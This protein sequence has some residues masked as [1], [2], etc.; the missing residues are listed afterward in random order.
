MLRSKLRFKRD[1]IVSV[2]MKTA[3]KVAVIV[4]YTYIKENNEF[5]HS[6]SKIICI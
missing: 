1:E 6:L 4:F 5:R 3:I 2:D